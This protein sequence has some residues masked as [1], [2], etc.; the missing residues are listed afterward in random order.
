MMK[1]TITVV[2]PVYNVERY[3]DRCVESICAQ[4]HG[5]L[6]IILI[7][8]GSSDASGELCDKWAR[9]DCRVHVIHQKNGGLSAA[10]N[11]GL[12]VAHG[13]WI[14][15]VDGDDSIACDTAEKLLAAAEENHC[16]ISVCNIIRVFD[17]G[18]T[19][20]FYR[21]V[22]EC[23]VLSGERRFD[24]LL[25]PSVCNKLFSVNLFDTV[26]FPVG[27]Y[28]EDTYVYHELVFRA[29]RL[30]LNGHDGYYYLMRRG[31]I[32]GGERY[33]DRYFDMIDAVYTRMTFL[34]E[35]GVDFYGRQAAL[36]MYAAVANAE[37]NIKKTPKNTDKLCLMKR[38]Y[39]EAY[40]HLK[41]SDVG[42]KQK[43]R[44]AILRYAPCIH[45]AIY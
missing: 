22:T 27:K 25:Q 21:P 8:D 43:I 12:D 15:F 16:D 32:L 20:P 13:K 2:V 7:D 33:C 1:D 10:R 29:Q 42:I 37:K 26:R 17:D 38:Q 24:T 41:L 6:E 36:S 39:R 31:S 19:E 11:A 3:L 44:L 34:F 45:R 14:M 5:E 40:R 4:T 18:G 35:N 23:E 28:Y 9:D 30:A